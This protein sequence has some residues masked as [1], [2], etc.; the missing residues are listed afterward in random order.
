MEFFFIYQN[1]P[2]NSVKIHR[3]DCGFCQQGHGAHQNHGNNVNGQWHI[4]PGQGYP[5]YQDCVTVAIQIAQEM[6]TNFE[7]CQVCNPF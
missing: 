3:G 7:N 4:G 1:Y 2:T 6:N 5:T